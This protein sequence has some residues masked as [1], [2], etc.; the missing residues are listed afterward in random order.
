MNWALGGG[1]LELIPRVTD[2][3]ISWSISVHNLEHSAEFFFYIFVIAHWH[4]FQKILN[5]MP[6][7]AVLYGAS[8]VCILII[9]LVWAILFSLISKLLKDSFIKIR[10]RTVVTFMNKSLFPYKCSL[11]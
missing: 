4:Y 3:V 10:T 1:G 5:G 2:E 7:D 11:K 6:T 9:Q 8:K